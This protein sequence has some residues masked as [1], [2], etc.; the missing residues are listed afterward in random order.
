MPDSSPEPI[1]PPEPAGPGE[2]AG[3]PPSPA[4]EAPPP[5]PE[6]RRSW[7]ARFFLWWWHLPGR[8]ARNAREIVRENKVL[9]GVVSFIVA[10]VIVFLWRDIFIRI[11]PGGCSR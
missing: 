7:P 3:S 6:R 2:P 8:M 11:G 10:F 1:T 4:A 5:A 9:L